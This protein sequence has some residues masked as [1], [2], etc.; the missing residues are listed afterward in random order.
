SQAAPTGFGPF[1]A[2]P[3][4]VAEPLPRRARQIEFVG[5]SHTV[6][7][8]VTSP[9]RTCSEADVWATTDTS[10]GFGAMLA[11]RYGAD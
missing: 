11:R 8:G 3:G 4:T 6:G 7:Y 2:E 9:T 10:R 1:Y 5:D